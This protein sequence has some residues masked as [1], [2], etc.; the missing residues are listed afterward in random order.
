MRII[1]PQGGQTGSAYTRFQRGNQGQQKINFIHLLMCHCIGVP[2]Y[3]M[4]TNEMN[5]RLFCRDT[6]LRDN[7]TV[8]LG[9][10]IR[11]LAPYPIQR[12]MNGI[13]LLRTM[14]PAIVMMTPSN[15]P[16]IQINKYITANQTGVAILKN[17]M[18]E[19]RRMV[20]VQTSCLGKLCDKARP[21]DWC[22]KQNQGCG[23]YGTT[24][25]ST[26]NAALMHHITL[27]NHGD[28]I[29]EEHFSSTKFNRIFMDRDIPPNTM[30]TALE[31][32]EA[33]KELEKSIDDCIGE[34]NQ[35]DGF[36][37]LLWYSR[38]EMNN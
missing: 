6:M 27:H 13:P 22:Y 29:K 18:L 12:N 15:V 4:I 17:V 21:L 25:L 32:T 14:F 23:C 1:T 10:Y 36:E 33:S 16:L 26:S 9:T 30:V 7:G 28:S 34:I 19:V 38:G 37:V 5:R 24:S 11:L 20:P 8:T 2:C 31:Q 35:N 3:I